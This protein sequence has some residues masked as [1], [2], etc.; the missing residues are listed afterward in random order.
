ME[1]DDRGGAQLATAHGSP[2]QTAGHAQGARRGAHGNHRGVPS[3]ARPPDR[4]PAAPPV[5]RARRP[6]ERLPLQV[7][8][9]HFGRLWLPSERSSLFQGLGRGQIAA[10]SPSERLGGFR[11]PPFGACRRR[12]PPRTAAPRRRSGM[13]GSLKLAAVSFRVLHSIQAAQCR[14]ERSG[15]PCAP[16]QQSQPSNAPPLRHAPLPVPAACAL[17]TVIAH[18]TLQGD[19]HTPAALPPLPLLPQPATQAGSCGAAALPPQAHCSMGPHG[20]A[21]PCR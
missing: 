21:A 3:A 11:A 6:H 9:V 15:C 10:I 12:R 19:I 16:K 2:R 5:D 14:A 7:R 8:E 4:A 17:T 18:L 20:G 1:R 13:V